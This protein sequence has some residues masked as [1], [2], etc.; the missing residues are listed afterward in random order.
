MAT[1]YFDG[2]NNTYSA[3][4]GWV[5]RLRSRFTDSQGGVWVVEVIDQHT[6][7]GS[8]FSWPLGTPKEFQLGPDGFTWEMDSKSDTFQ[9]GALATSVSFDLQVT[10]TDHDQIVEVIKGSYDGR[11]GVALYSLNAVSG[12]DLNSGNTFVRPYWF[13][14]VSNEDVNWFP[15]TH[16]GTIRIQAHCGLALL[17][18]IPYQQADG[19]AYDDWTDLGTHIKRI[20]THI[21][22]TKLWGYTATG[23]GVKQTTSNLSVNPPLLQTHQWFFD[24]TYHLTNSVPPYCILGVTG[25]HSSTFYDIER[26][27][28]VFGGSY[29]SSK[30]ISC[31]EV[32]KNIL[33][34]LNLRM[35]QY[36]GSFVAHNPLEAGVN[37]SGF[38]SMRARLEDLDDVSQSLVSL[39]VASKEVELYSSGFE[40]VAGV[41]DAFLF[42]LRESKSVHKKGGSKIILGGGGYSIY[43]ENELFGITQ[44]PEL[45]SSS[46]ATVESNGAITLVGNLI[47]QELGNFNSPSANVNTAMIGAKPIIS[48][49]IKVG[50]YY[51]KRDLTLS[52]NSYNIDR[53]V[54]SDLT[55]KPHVQSG[56]VEWTTTE[57]TYDFVFPFPG[58]TQEP[59]V[60]WDSTN[61]IDVVGGLHIA[62]RDGNPDPFKY[63]TGFLGIGTGTQHTS[64]EADISWTLPQLPSIAT[65][66]VGVSFKAS[67][68]YKYRDSNNNIPYGPSS[69]GG[70]QGTSAYYTPAYWDYFK[71]FVNVEDNDAD[72]TFSAQ[73]STNYANEISGQSCLGDRYTDQSTGTLS[74]NDVNDL[75][76]NYKIAQQN[77]VTLEDTTTTSYAIH[78]LIAREN[79]FMRAQTLRTR[80]TTVA[81][82]VKTGNTGRN[83]LFS[84]TAGG[85]NSLHPTLLVNIIDEATTTSR[86]WY[87]TSMAFTASSAAYDLGLILVD[88]D[89]TITAEEDDNKENREK[90]G[91]NGTTDS[92]D[93]GNVTNGIGLAGGKGTIQ[94]SINGLNETK[95]KVS[96]ITVTA[97]VDLDTMKS[98]VITNTSN[99]ASNDTDIAALN[100]VVKTAFTGGG[101]GVYSTNSKDTT[102]SFMGLTSTTAKLQAGGG[103]TA[104]DI[105]ETSPGTIDLSVQVGPA[106]SEVSSTALS[107]QGTTG[108]QLPNI[109]FNGNFSGIEIGDLD[110][111][112]VSGIQTNQVLAWNGSNFVPVNQ[113]GGGGTADT[114]EVELKLIFLEK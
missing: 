100:A 80:N 77:W 59:A 47:L 28:D 55:Y 21:P 74:L 1:T 34:V 3:A 20:M 61:E 79:L 62:L 42:P 36:N 43:A 8:G 102:S 12:T 110:D 38:Y 75:Y 25:A 70:L 14:V 27:E 66:H 22:T 18:S 46:L 111:V 56:D 31:A 52:S 65:E 10:D 97:A 101:A 35:F 53:N 69:A 57:S 32:L 113:S 29:T 4:S 86:K 109:I 60:Y 108:S 88:T 23:T 45:R 13:G 9:T 15:Y 105:E 98:D 92:G 91:S 103:N 94:N 6:G 48:M 67:I 106:G 83:A 39:S 5:C 41:Q 30:A 112:T 96:L 26:E 11:F 7:S 87:V 84:T 44:T 58:S 99:I 37:V 114:T 51:L 72:I 50:D 71:C 63:R 82:V 49:T 90:G 73:Q 93:P 95:E 107:L 2:T 16:P 81:G 40:Q 104:I 89:R 19:S 24:K 64:I 78:R 85:L 76:N 33:A 68:V 17:N 54:A